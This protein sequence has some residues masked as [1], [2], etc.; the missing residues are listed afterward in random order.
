MAEV[1][2]LR[3]KS[4]LDRLIEAKFR[5]LTAARRDPR[6]SDF[7]YRLYSELLDEYVHRGAGYRFGALWPAVGTV[8]HGLTK[9]RRTVQR[10]THDLSRLGYLELVARGGGRLPGVTKATTRYRLPG[11][12]ATETP[13]VAVTETPPLAMAEPP[14]NPIDRT[15]EKKTTSSS[16]TRA[17]AKRLRHDDEKGSRLAPHW[18]PS[19]VDVA[20]AENLGLDPIQTAEGFRD[21]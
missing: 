1:V 20:F 5:L 10:A 21:Y 9:H 7:A 19:A 17:R 3:G 14:P 13:P 2:H 18:Y 11:L 8:A 15:P 12:T 16:S 6:V 4:E